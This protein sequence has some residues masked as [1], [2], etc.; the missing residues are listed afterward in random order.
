MIFYD[1][2]SGTSDSPVVIVQFYDGSAA[3]LEERQQGGFPG[4]S[5]L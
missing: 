4:G 3:R 1:E 5:Y 2:I